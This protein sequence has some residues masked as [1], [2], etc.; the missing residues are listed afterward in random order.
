MKLLFLLFGFLICYSNVDAQLNCKTL[1]G[2]AGDSVICYHSNNK[3]STL[4]WV[5][6]EHQNY[7]HFKAFDNSGNQVFEGNH[8]YLHGG[9]SLDVK[10]YENGSIRSARA[11]FQPDGGIQHYDVT[12]F[13]N[14][15]GTFNHEEDN[16][17]DRMHTLIQVEQVPSENL[18]KKTE[19]KTADSLT[20][21]LHNSTRKKIKVLVGFK[22]SA[23]PKQLIT[24]KK[25]G[26]LVI[27]K[28]VAENNKKDPQLYFDFDILPSRK[29]ISTFVFYEPTLSK[30]K[31]EHIFIL[32]N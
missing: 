21:I 2:K 10:Y 20:F 19:K 15:D 29:P 6:V 23:G 25:N 12:T 11:T 26:Q 3:V 14:E 5:S 31:T 13:F 16:S 30:D 28:F 22:N 8:G 17:W 1:K 7:Y 18:S 4:E 32:E 9:A 24:I 27:G